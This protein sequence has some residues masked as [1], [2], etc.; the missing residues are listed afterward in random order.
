MNQQK[1]KELKEQLDK[2]EKVKIEV[3]LIVKQLK[4]IESK[5]EIFMNEEENAYDNLPNSLQQGEKGSYMLKTIDQMNDVIDG[6]NF[7]RSE[8]SSRD[9]NFQDAITDLTKLLVAKS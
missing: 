6:I 1:R 8:L 9:D 4:E 5:I 3:D 2:L 7:V